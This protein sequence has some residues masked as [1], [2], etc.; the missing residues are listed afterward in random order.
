MCKTKHHHNTQAV[1]NEK[2]NR[3]Q[4]AAS[5]VRLVQVKFREWGSLRNAYIIILLC[6]SLSSIRLRG[7]MSFWLEW[8]RHRAIKRLGTVRARARYQRT[9]LMQIWTGWAAVAK[10]QGDMKRLVFHLHQL[11]ERGLNVKLNVACAFLHMTVYTIHTQDAEK[12]DSSPSQNVEKKRSP[13]IN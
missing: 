4:Q 2:S 11:Y 13:G 8:S 9:L 3:A 10:E 12:C 6:L 1:L 7:A 5:K